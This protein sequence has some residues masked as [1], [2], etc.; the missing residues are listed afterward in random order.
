[1]S[2]AQSLGRFFAPIA[3]PVLLLAAALAWQDVGVSRKVFVILGYGPYLAAV[4]GVVLCAWF[5]RSRAVFALVLVTAGYWLC[6]G[7]LTQGPSRTPFGQVGYAAYGILLPVNLAVLGF[8]EERGIVTPRGLVRSGV[9]LGQILAVTAIMTGFGGLLE[10]SLAARLQ[11]WTG[12]WLH[13]RLFSRTADAWTS[14]PQLAL[15]TFPAAGVLLLTRALITRSTM[16]A[17]LLGALGAVFLALHG[18]GREALPAIFF[19]TSGMILIATVV[20]DSYRMAFLDE[21][22]GLPARRA[23]MASLK[24]LGN[25]YTIA[26]LDVDHFKKF[27]DT[28][29]HDVGDD[30]LRMVASKLAK[31]TGGGRPF[32]YGGEEFTVLFPNRGIDEAWYH[33]EAVR[34]ALAGT[35]FVVRGA[36]RPE[37]RPKEVP[38]S[39]ADTP[40]VGVTI[41]IGVAERSAATPDPETVIKAADEALY[42]A[43]EAGR[44][45]VER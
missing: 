22:T 40:T 15:I 8:F 27:N 6:D 10:T 39:R 28:Y 2:T 25:R 35:R 9:I 44:N 30:V 7:F 23:L 16:D 18:I 45:R 43:K 38:A 36:N 24:K 5:N 34:A 1:M 37:T 31:V 13:V 4:L 19:T 3:L 42:R 41:S 12:D 14:L 17:G 32:R 29:G 26:M 20:Q 33:L 11:A 21:L